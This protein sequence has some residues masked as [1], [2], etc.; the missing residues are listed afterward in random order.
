MKPSR[1]L[2]LIIIFLLISTFVVL[3]RNF[4]IGSFSVNLPG[5]SWHLGSLSIE[6]DLNT[7]FGLDIAGGSHLVFEADMSKIKIENRDDALAAAA[8][9]VERRVNLFG[10][11]EPVVQAVKTN[12]NFR[13]N[14]DLPGV[15]DVTEAANLIGQ[16]AQLVFA[17]VVEEKLVTTDLT[18]ADLVRS[19]V[20]FDSQTG[21]PIV[22]LTFSDEGGKKFS[23]LTGR[24]IGKAM[25][26][27][28]DNQVISAP[29]VSDKIT[30]GRAVITGDFTL[31]EVKRLVI[32]LNSG[33]LPI[34]LK[35]IEQ[36]TVGPTLGQ[37]SVNLSVRAGLVGIIAV[38][39]FMIAYY[40]RLGVIA[41]MT[42]VMY[43]VF[44]LALF[45]LVPIVL[46]LPG[47]AGFL[48]S[49]GMAVDSNILIFERF[50][51]EKRLG[52]EFSQALEVAFGRA[53][54][55][56]RDANFVI[57]LTSFI[58]FNPL[59]WSFLHTSGPIRGFAATLAIG[60]L[61]SLFTGIVITRTLLR[62]FARRK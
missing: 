42:L 3:P 29:V 55:S 48:L 26:I 9:T 36:R 45:K 50:K 8:G 28:L 25:P 6:R 14:V 20:E 60:V 33:S 22:G 61:L 41:A 35:I 47:I 31:D 59:D 51:E 10:V 1:L 43:G 52:L 16:T 5:I 57:L 2:L 56:I 32:Q 49:V 24:N 13:I 38:A 46:T 19:Q 34:P 21:K 54:N 58:L 37:E 7:K 15:S 27:L 53:W 44:V 30:G 40:G 39:V 4:K 17:E 12:N 18:G 23:E 11:S 62:T